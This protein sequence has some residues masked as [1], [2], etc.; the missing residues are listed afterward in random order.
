MITKKKDAVELLNQYKEL[1]SK[2]IGKECIIK[3]DMHESSGFIVED[4]VQRSLKDIKVKPDKVEFD[5]KMKTPMLFEI[6][7]NQAALLFTFDDTIV[8]PLG[9]GVRLIIPLNKPINDRDAIE[10][11]IRLS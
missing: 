5:G 6:V 8:S 7:N 4:I 1:F 9:N 11:D 10:V 2:I 3:F